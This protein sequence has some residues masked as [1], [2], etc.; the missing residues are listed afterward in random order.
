MMN[1][2]VRG[3][4]SYVLGP[5]TGVVFLI[6]DK[7][8]FVRFHAAQ[9]TLV[10]GGLWIL[11]MI[12][13]MTLI[14]LPLAGILGLVTFVLWLFLIFKAYQGEEFHLPYIGKYVDMILAKVK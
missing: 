13:S 8:P 10:F 12:F 7:D 11:S 14:L 3:A 6:T 5:L 9:S 2:N 4:L 1:K